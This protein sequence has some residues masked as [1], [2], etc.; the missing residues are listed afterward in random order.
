M[1]LV[2]HFKLSML[3]SSSNEA[4]ART[5]VAAFVSQL[6]PTMDELSEI[7]TAVSEA[8]TNCIIHAYRD[9]IGII[10]IET[11][12]FEGGRI[13]IKIRDKGCGIADI[14]RAMEPMYTTGGSERA[15]LGFA[16]M[17]NFM[18]RI[19]VSSMPERGTTV[20][21]VKTISRREV[22]VNTGEPFKKCIQETG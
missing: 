15:G 9:K 8:V 20:T 5:A 7:K 22:R 21:M 14:Q 18:D 16:V 17:E 19:K 3:S 1:T 13:S 4:V 11:S 12:L 6:D 2:N 10:Y